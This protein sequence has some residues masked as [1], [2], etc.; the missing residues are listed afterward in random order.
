MLFRK[1][2]ALLHETILFC[3]STEIRTRGYVNNSQNLPTSRTQRTQGRNIPVQE[4]PS[5]RYSICCT[6]MMFVI[7]MQNTYLLVCCFWIHSVQSVIPDPA[8]LSGRGCP[9]MFYNKTFHSF[10]FVGAPK[11]KPG[12]V[13]F[14]FV[15][16]LCK[17]KCFNMFCFWIHSVQSAINSPAQL[18]GRGFSYLA[19]WA[20]TVVFPIYFI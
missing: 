3:K 14:G 4:N 8:Q 20:Q 5:L 15:R 9:Y 7:F 6:F 16:L 11:W 19:R 18:S 13:T 10:T 12:C 2:C 1:M 17:N